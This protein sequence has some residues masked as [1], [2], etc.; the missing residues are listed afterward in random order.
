MILNK[1]I[2]KK[3]ERIDNIEKI[4]PLYLNQR[5]VF[6]LLAIIED[7]F[8]SMYSVQKQQSDSKNIDSSIDVAVGTG[9]AFTFLSA[10]LGEKLS[11]SNM[12]M[13]NKHIT[14]DRIHTPTSLFSKLLEY[15]ASEIKEINSAKEIAQISTGDFV[16]IK[17]KINQNELIKF[18]DSFSSIMNLT[19]LFQPVSSG[20]NQSNNKKIADQVKGIADSLRIAGIMDLICK[21]NENFEIVLQSEIK[22]FENQFI[23]MIEEGEYTVLGKVIKVPDDNGDSI[24]LMR[25]TSLSLLKESIF[26]NL[27]Q[28]LDTKEMLAAGIKMGNVRTCINGI[29]VIPIAIYA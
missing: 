24:N 21:T 22:Y 2:S 14:E 7:G 27:I 29:L 25:N 12:H 3:T 6:D 10:K 9:N 17:G 5:I 15:L 20:K 16:K 26:Q 18:F 23:G 8:S 11:S 13:S 28:S 1:K 19:T 4:I